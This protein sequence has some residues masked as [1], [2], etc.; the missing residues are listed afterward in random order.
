[1]N[2]LVC[3]LAFCLF[4]IFHVLTGAPLGSPDPYPGTYQSP[5][6][7]SSAALDGVLEI[8]CW[9]YAK[10][11]GGVV[12]LHR[13]PA[14]QELERDSMTCVEKGTG[15]T[16]C[17]LFFS[18]LG[19]DTGNYADWRDS[20]Q[21]YVTCLAEAFMGRQYCPAN[22]V[23]NETLQGCDYPYNVQPPCGTKGSR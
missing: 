4:T 5:W 22:L 14:S 11:V 8:G 23:F 20:C 3:C 10:C 17:S 21:T 13:C 2:T 16:D 19:L 7:C 15:H 12:S 9:G 6:N 18:C 1:M